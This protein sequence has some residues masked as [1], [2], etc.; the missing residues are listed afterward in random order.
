[1]PSGGITV[2]LVR[3]SASEDGTDGFPGAAQER[4]WEG[5]P[6]RRLSLLAE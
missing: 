3:E 6:E 5:V 1:M 2:G 4:H